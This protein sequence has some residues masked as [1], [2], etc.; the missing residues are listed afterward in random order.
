M[1]TQYSNSNF[2]NNLRTAQSRNTF[3]QL[4]HYICYT[5]Y[6]LKIFCIALMN[7]PLM[8]VSL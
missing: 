8:Q 6:I 5:K 4:G 7:L 2:M 3:Q 1:N